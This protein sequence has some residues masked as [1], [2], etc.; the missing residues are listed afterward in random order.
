MHMQQLPA[1]PSPSGLPLL[2]HTSANSL[3]SN[4]SITTSGAPG[5]LL[6]FPMS[7]TSSGQHHLPTHHP[8]NAPSSTTGS[9]AAAA[10]AAAA[11]HKSDYQQ[12]IDDMKATNGIFDKG[13]IEEET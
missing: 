12:R 5:S 13:Q 6:G 8:A 1:H 3:P 10:A 7:L 4:P 9:I 11:A 2:N